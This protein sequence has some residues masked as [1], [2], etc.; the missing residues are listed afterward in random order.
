MANSGVHSESQGGKRPRNTG[1]GK[2]T[3]R[4]GCDVETLSA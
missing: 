2:L 4:Q 1:G 3:L